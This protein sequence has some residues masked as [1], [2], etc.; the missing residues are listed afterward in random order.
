MRILEADG[1]SSV[2]CPICHRDLRL[3]TMT[4]L[5][6]HGYTS[7]EDFLRD[8]PGTQLVSKEYEDRA[9]EIR[10]NTLT[11]LNKSPEQR[12]KASERA[13]T[14]NSDSEFQREMNHRRV[15]TDDSKEKLSVSLKK[16][17]SDGRHK[18]PEPNYGK[19]IPYTTQDGRELILRSFLECRVCKFLELNNLGFEYESF[20]IPYE[21]NGS[22]HQ[23]IPDFY[24]RD[25]NL[26]V[27]VKPSD[28]QDSEN[29]LAK[30]KASKEQG[31]NFIFVSDSDLKD[32]ETLLN[33]IIALRAK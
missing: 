11:N 13:K 4:H 16:A 1:I 30:M 17:Y 10:R 22:V 31:Y 27:E 21:W 29:A 3:I 8:Y 26:I 33:K 7:K 14:R 23:Y 20:S 6:S 19:R 15:W 12:A 18:L 2:E 5:K 28:R 24:L 32:Y 9:N 25:E